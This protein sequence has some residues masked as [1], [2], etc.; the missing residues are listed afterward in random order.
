MSQSPFREPQQAWQT[1]PATKT[2]AEELVEQE[3]TPVEADVPRWVREG[4][5]SDPSTTVMGKPGWGRVGEASGAPK[6][7]P[8]PAPAARQGARH[9]VAGVDEPV[10][11]AAPVLVREVRPVPRSGYRKAL[12]VLSGGLINP[13]LSTAE[14]REA[15]LEGRVSR[16]VIGRHVTTYLCLKGGIAKTSTCIGVAKFCAQLS[17]DSVFAGDFNPDAGDLA[18]RAVGDDLAGVAGVNPLAQQVDAIHSVGELSRYTSS[19]DRLT[20]LPGE[21]DP[22][23]GESLTSTEF[24]AI[25]DLVGRYYSNVHVDAGTGMTHPIMKGILA[26]TDTVVVPASYSISGAKRAAETIEWLRR[27]GFARLADNAIVALTANQ[28]VS[29]LVDK[30][31]VRGLFPDNRVVVVPQDPHVADGA[32]IR[33]EQMRPET[34]DAYGEIAA[35]L[36]DR[37]SARREAG[38]R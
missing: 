37:W 22:Q 6:H 36:S 27:N 35:M 2:P 3:S 11:R 31:A 4:I 18:E 24:N 15:T 12:Y 29:G 21:P 7:T 16:P 9:A 13:G 33:L 5:V 10:L 32:A 20:V 38:R 17:P 19:A 28:N 26:E 25:L 23:L 30:A 34:R 14:K 8:A 1:P